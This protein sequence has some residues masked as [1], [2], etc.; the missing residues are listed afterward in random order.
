MRAVRLL[1]VLLTAASCWAA[2]VA[3]QACSRGPQEVVAEAELT[4]FRGVSSVYRAVAEDFSPSNPS[5]PGDNFTVRLRAT[6]T[7]WGDDPARPVTLKFTAGAC[8]EWKLWGFNAPDKSIDG[9]GYL[10][11]VAP[12][13]AKDASYLRIV[14]DDAELGQSMFNFW[15]ETRAGNPAPGSNH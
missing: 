7:L 10:V 4:Y 12:E 15:R 5:Y 14:P 13:A 1:V 9:R 11:F 3:A 8:T 2:P 6:E